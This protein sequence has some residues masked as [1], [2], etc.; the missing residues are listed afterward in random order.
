MAGYARIGVGAG[1]DVT[2]EIGG[3]GAL[4]I[5]HEYSSPVRF[6]GHA[7]NMKTLIGYLLTTLWREVLLQ[8]GVPPFQV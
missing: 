2:H 6:A 8:E 5:T 7:L 4:S 3:D 1:G